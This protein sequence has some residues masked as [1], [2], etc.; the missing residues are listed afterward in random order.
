MV[1]FL[2]WDHL[3]L[4]ADLEIGSDLDLD[5]ARGA[6]GAFAAEPE[7]TVVP[8]MEDCPLWSDHPALPL[9]NGKPSR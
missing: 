2:E 1:R 6:S 5:P 9:R 8:S 3:S 4:A 7:T